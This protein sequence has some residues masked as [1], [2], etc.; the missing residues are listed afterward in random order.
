M[1][2]PKAQTK[3]FVLD[4]S[5]SKA[6]GAL[7]M[8]R[9]SDS[10]MLENNEITHV[11][12]LDMEDDEV[13]LR[14]ENLRQTPK[15]GIIY[16]RWERNEFKKP[17]PVKLDENGDPIEDEEEEEEEGVEP[18]PKIGRPLDETKL[19]CRECDSYSNILQELVHYTSDVGE[20]TAFNRII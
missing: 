6:S 4:L 9:F 16:S 10:G 14:A 5:F 12:D 11:V 18:L 7:W 3:G 15:N 8:Q 19:V 1:R 17:K 20:R 13:R 2:D